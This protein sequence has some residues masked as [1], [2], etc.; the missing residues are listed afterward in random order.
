MIKPIL[1][2]TLLYLAASQCIHMKC[3]E[4]TTENKDKC[5]TLTMAP[6]EAEVKKCASGKSC[7][8]VDGETTYCEDAKKRVG[9]K[10]TAASECFSGKCE[11]NKCTAIEDG[12][13]CTVHE[14]CD[15][16]SYCDSTT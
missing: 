2:A 8:K 5:K 4:D 12:K 6:P 9:E 10:C 15:K 13:A 14:D 16:T 7:S 11:D 1:F 3:M